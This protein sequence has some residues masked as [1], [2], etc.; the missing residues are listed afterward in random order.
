MAVAFKRQNV[1]CKAVKEEAVMADDHGA[2]S[3]AFQRFFK[4]RKCFNVQIV[5]RFIEQKYVAALLQHLRHV[6][7]VAFTAGQ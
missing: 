5:G 2:A 1:R 4:S 3:E 7:A 6:H